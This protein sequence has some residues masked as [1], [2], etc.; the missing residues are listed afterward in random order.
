MQAFFPTQITR[1][2]A[3]FLVVLT[4]VVPLIGS[5]IKPALGQMMSKL[6]KKQVNQLGVTLSSKC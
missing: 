4:Y 5:S 1:L 3:K 6:V 2:Y